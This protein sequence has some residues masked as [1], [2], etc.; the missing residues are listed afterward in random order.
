MKYG[1]D[2]LEFE[3]GNTKVDPAVSRELPEGCKIIST[4]KHGVSFWAQTGRIDVL[5][6]DGTPQ[7]FFIKVLS[8]DLGMNITKGEFE[9]MRA[10]YTVLPSFVPRP[11]ACGTYGTIPDNHFILC[12]FREMTHGMP[13]PDEFAAQLSTLHGKSVSPNGKFGFHI[14][15]YAGMLPQFVGWEDSWE[16]FFAKSMRQALNL[17]IERKGP[18]E[19]LAVLSKALFERVIP[20]LLSP[21]ECDGRTVKPSLVHGDLWHANAGIDVNN[22]KPLIFDACSFFAHNECKF[23]YGSP[24]FTQLNEGEFEDEFGQWRPA[25]NRFGDEYVAA[26]KR[27]IEVSPPEEDF[28]GR[29]DL[30]RL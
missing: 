26:Y 1:V 2:R 3:A 28:E 17:E 21:L 13:D 15:T 22:G 14:T 23:F 8:K 12:E 19:D 16:T 18:S 10:I 4:A 7:S 11:I 9:S 5:L 6:R 24:L 25:C 29:L 30:Y 20:R 27:F